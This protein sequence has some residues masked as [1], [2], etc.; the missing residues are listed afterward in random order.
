MQA[1][2]IIRGIFQNGKISGRSSST[3]SLLLD[4]CAMRYSRTRHISL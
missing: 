2:R 3:N 1:T 4:C